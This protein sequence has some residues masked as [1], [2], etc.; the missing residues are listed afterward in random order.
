MNFVRRSDRLAFEQMSS[1]IRHGMRVETVMNVRHEDADEAVMTL[2]P[3]HIEM[4]PE[5]TATDL[6]FWEELAREAD[7][8][9]AE[10]GKIDIRADELLELARNRVSR[11]RS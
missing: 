2:L 1:N 10:N 11:L 4:E 7:H 6:S 9:R 5:P 3:I 8:I